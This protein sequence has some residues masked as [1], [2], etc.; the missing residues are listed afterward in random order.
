MKVNHSDS[1]SSVPSVVSCYLV[2]MTNQPTKARSH[3]HPQPQPSHGQ[4][5]RN[6]SAKSR[7]R[8]LPPHRLRHHSLERRLLRRPHYT[9]PG[10]RLPRL[11]EPC[12]RFLFVIIIIV[13]LAAK[14]FIK[15]PSS[16]SCSSRSSTLSTGS[17]RSRSRHHNRQ[18]IDGTDPF[19][20]DTYRSAKART[21]QKV[22]PTPVNGDCETRRASG[23]Q[24]SHLL[25]LQA[26]DSRPLAKHVLDSILLL[27]IRYHL[28][29][30]L[31]ASGAAASIVIMI[32][33][34]LL[35]MWCT[36]TSHSNSDTNTHA[37]SRTVRLDCLI[38]D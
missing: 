27:I 10:H 6:S 4:R 8:P 22:P 16:K 38:I 25:P 7:S 14:T 3:P 35:L 26:Y 34:G 20:P 19:G 33:Q 1:E 30:R 31:L 9:R 28:V 2:P 32:L 21:A 12:S 29:P 11:V 37:S 18:F 24:R 13:F 23:P 17:H 36:T 5:R 15:S